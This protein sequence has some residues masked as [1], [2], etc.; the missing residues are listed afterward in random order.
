LNRAAEAG[1]LH[2]LNAEFSLSMPYN[3]W[4][5]I[6]GATVMVM[7]THGADQLNVQRVLACRS[8]GDGR[9]ALVLS[10]VIILPLFLLFLFV[11]VMLWV[12]FQQTPP[13]IPLPE[14]QAGFTQNDYVFPVFII[15][16]APPVV[17]GFMIVAILSAAMSSVSSALSALASVS[18]MD[19]ARGFMKR[20]R[21]EAYFLKFSRASTVFWGLMLIWVAW[22][23]REVKL[24]LDWAFSLNGLTNGAM[25]GGLALSLWWKRGSAWPVIAGMLA[26]LGFM[27]F[28][29][30][31]S[32][33]VEAEGGVLRRQVA[34]PWYTLIGAAVTLT[35]AW[36][37]RL[38]LGRRQKF[39]RPE[40]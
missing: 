12:Y 35:V 15:T 13:A 26:S 20:E 17:R 2:W 33:A 28:I 38:V 19:L 16:E 3:L 6:I 22:Q 27:I 40:A 9:R 14:S 5:G 37:A 1:K 7:A 10:A 11:G 29:S 4:M 34:W 21:S 18:T 25:L 24:V 39:S 31:F 23:S 36:L 8:V 30:R 32:W